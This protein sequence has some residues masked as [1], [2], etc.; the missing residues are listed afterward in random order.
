MSGDDHLTVHPL[1]IAHQPGKI[2]FIKVIDINTWKVMSQ[3]NYL[4]TEI[5]I[6]SYFPGFDKFMTRPPRI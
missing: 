4:L 3:E 2:V 5:V 1:R 6:L